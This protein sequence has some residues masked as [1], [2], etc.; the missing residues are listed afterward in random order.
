MA[1][2][3]FVIKDRKFTRLIWKSLRTGYFELREYQTFLIGTPQGSVISPILT[4]ICMHQLDLFIEELKE[5]YDK[6]TRTRGLN[7]YKRLN[8][9]LNKKDSLLLKEEKRKLATKM[10]LLPST[11]IRLLRRRLDHKNSRNPL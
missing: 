2:V 4:N 8:W 5:Q 11:V 9:R 3:E 1:A 10:R 6:G 7:A